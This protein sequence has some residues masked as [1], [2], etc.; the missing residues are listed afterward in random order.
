MTQTIEFEQKLARY[1]ELILKVGVNLPEDGK[2]CIK[3]PLEA[4][5]LVRQIN[6]A[7]YQHGALDVD[8]SYYDAHQDLYLY[9]HGSDKAVAYLPD[10]L[11]EKQQHLVDDGYA[12]ISIAGNDP[13][14]L[15]QANPDRIA[16]RSKLLS[17]AM[18]KPSEAI[19]SFQVNW[20]VAA[21]ATPTW[22]K[23]IFPNLDEN[24]A[25]A[26]LWDNIFKVT[27]A[28]QA[29]PVAAWQTHID[30]L[31]NMVK[32]LNAKQYD[33]LHFKNPEGT[34]LTI[35]LA[36][37]HIWQGGAEKAQNGIIGVPNMPTDEIFTAPHSHKVNGWAVASKPLSVRGQ[38]IENIRMRFEDGK[39][40]EA[41]AQKG[42]DTLQKLLDTDEGASRLGEVA[43]VPASAPVAQTDTLF[44]NTLFDENA[45][46]HI[47]L[48][49]CYPTT[50]TNGQ[51][52]EQCSAAGGNDSLIH[53]DWMIGNTHTDVDG[54]T[55]NG[56]REALMRAGEWV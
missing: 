18:R 31:A 25:M 34:D 12:F 33:A 52:K 40:V 56:E 19:G 11:A 37:G 21:M 17:K 3:A 50:I 23:A 29:D 15:A 54:L 5:E 22:A 48:G 43:L 16:K 27:R 13:N 10:W 41:T 28:D 7:A 38:L 8:I 20:T 30:H 44:L 2:L 24:T 47:A 4:V 14:L 45:A 6:K 55:A 46:S 1:A 26:R 51:D 32:T 42:Q 49:R 39:A 35:G 53:V 9:Q 36:K